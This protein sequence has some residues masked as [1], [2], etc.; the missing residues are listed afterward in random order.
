MKATI[1][2]EPHHPRRP[3][4][5]RNQPPK[6]DHI[7]RQPGD[8]ASPTQSTARIPTAA[9]SR[10]PQHD[11]G[12]PGP[13]PAVGGHPAERHTFGAGHI[14]GRGRRNEITNAI[15]QTSPQV[16]SRRCF[17]GIPAR[18]RDPNNR[19]AT[20][21]LAYAARSPSHRMS[22]IGSRHANGARERSRRSSRRKSGSM[23]AAE[24]SSYSTS[25]VPRRCQALPE[26][27]NPDRITDA[28]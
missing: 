9:S 13:S 2:R 12:Q 27:R 25:E 23:T 4:P 3:K 17:G 14:A 10:T 21:T 15:Q 11:R 1:H 8:Q 19:D 16:R 7:R 26:R 18:R 6:R 24:R 28:G 5:R 20:Q 22:A